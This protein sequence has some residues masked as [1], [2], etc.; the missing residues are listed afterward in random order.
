MTHCH[1]RWEYFWPVLHILCVNDC[2]QF[3]GGPCDAKL[4]IILLEDMWEIVVVVVV[5]EIVMIFFRLTQSSV[6][7]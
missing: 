4:S 7:K 6:L 1:F 3:L 5:N 2:V